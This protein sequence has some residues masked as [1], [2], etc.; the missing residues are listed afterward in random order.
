MSRMIKDA[1]EQ[2]LTDEQIDAT[3]SAL[4][5]G[6]EFWVVVGR[7]AFAFRFG[8]YSGPE[9]GQILT[10]C[11]EKRVAATVVAQCGRDFDW[12]AAT[13]IGMRLVLPNDLKGIRGWLA[14]FFART[15]RA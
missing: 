11:V 4:G 5:K 12:S 3:Y 8:P 14:R 10:Q 13:D 2:R 9:A 6:T 7:G 15:A 1:A